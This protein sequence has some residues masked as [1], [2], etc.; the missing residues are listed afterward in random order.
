MR[1]TTYIAAAAAACLAAAAAIPEPDSDCATH[2]PRPLDG[3]EQGALLGPAD[4]PYP[5]LQDAAAALRSLDRLPLVEGRGFMIAYTLSQRL[6]ASVAA[7]STGLLRRPARDAIVR[8][9]RRAY[10]A[11][12][13]DRVQMFGQVRL[14]T[15]LAA[16]G[17][18]EIPLAWQAVAHEWADG[19][20]PAE[21]EGRRWRALMEAWLDG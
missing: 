9:M 11:G 5:R 7:D 6:L 2:A 1:T 8:A 17:L 21:T 16:A 14:M 10:R 13:P 4:A 12:H 20:G 3:L 19:W 18:V 15:G